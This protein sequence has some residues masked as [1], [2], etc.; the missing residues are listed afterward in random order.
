MIDQRPDLTNDEA[1]ILE[2]VKRKAA[3]SEMAGQSW[4]VNACLLEITSMET[5]IA[6]LRK[7]IDLCKNPEVVTGIELFVGKK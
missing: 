1:Q 6:K 7:L 4:I 3:I 5:T 2:L